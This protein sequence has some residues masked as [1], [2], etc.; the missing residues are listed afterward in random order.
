[1]GMRYFHVVDDLRHTDDGFTNDGR[2]A[3]IQHPGK[4]DRIWEMLVLGA[5]LPR[6]PLSQSL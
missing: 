5:Y 3:A 2:C 6:R 4:A 1:V